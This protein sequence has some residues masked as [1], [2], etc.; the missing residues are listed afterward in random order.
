MNE[1]INHDPIYVL[2][3]IAK[4]R[5]HGGVEGAADLVGE[6]EKWMQGKT[7]GLVLQQRIRESLKW[8]ERLEARDEHPG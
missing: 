3:V 2:A 7:V 6:M 8:I 5:Q 4:A 1:R